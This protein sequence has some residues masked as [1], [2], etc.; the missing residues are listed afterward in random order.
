M[1]GDVVELGI[2]L[3]FVGGA[4]AIA[5]AEGGAFPGPPHHAQGEADAHV[6]SFHLELGVPSEGGGGQLLAGL[7]LRI[8]DHQAGAHGQG[9]GESVGDGGEHLDDGDGGVDAK[10]ASHPVSIIVGGGAAGG[11]HGQVQVQAI[12]KGI[13]IA[14]I[15]DESLSDDVAALVS[16]DRASIVMELHFSG[17]EVVAH[18][19]GGAVD[20]WCSGCRAIGTAG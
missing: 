12:A 10:V 16:G 2:Q 3:Q 8:V 5:Q 18:H 1:G 9:V 14:Q 7:N 17:K 11:A 20:L 15:G 6:V 4:G 19:Q 13:D